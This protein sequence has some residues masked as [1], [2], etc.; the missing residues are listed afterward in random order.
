MIKNNLVLDVPPGLGLL[1][2]AFEQVGYCVVAGPDLLWGRDMRNWHPARGAFEGII[3]G[4]PCQEFTTSFG[5]KIEGNHPKYGNLIPEWER[6]VF[7]AQPDW[8]LMENVRQAPIPEV[9]DYHIKSFL[10]NNRWTGAIQD[11]ERRFTFGSKSELNLVLEET[12]FHNP[13]KSPTVIGADSG[14]LRRDNTR[15]SPSLSEKCILQGL[16]GDFFKEP[17]PFKKSNAHEMVGNGVPLPM[18]KTI[19]RAVR[20]AHSALSTEGRIEG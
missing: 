8:F 14:L 15:F 11:R 7:E 18:G 6:I 12:L 3:G 5:R 16:P 13:I 17:S 4:P 2:M 10:Y 1:G 20:Q 19:A 9:T